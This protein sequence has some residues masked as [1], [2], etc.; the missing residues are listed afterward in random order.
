MTKLDKIQTTKQA[1][2]LPEQFLEKL[3]TF[4]KRIDQ[5]AN[6]KIAKSAEELDV[7]QKDIIQDRTRWY[8]LGN[9]KGRTATL[10]MMRNAKGILLNS[11][12]NIL[13]RIGSAASNIVLT[14]IVV[15]GSFTNMIL[16]TYVMSSGSHF[17]ALDLIMSCAPAF[18]YYDSRSK[19]WLTN[20]FK[21]E[22]I[23]DEL[24]QL[25]T[26]LRCNLYAEKEIQGFKRTHKYRVINPELFESN[27]EITQAYRRVLNRLTSRKDSYWK[28]THEL[29]TQN[30]SYRKIKNMLSRLDRGE[31]Y[32]SRM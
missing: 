25:E 14:P 19:E 22:E 13:E 7:I 20:Q 6:K 32:Q 4:Q 3:N 10:N 5:I 24:V 2:L 8:V 23:K 21:R 16:M 29:N 27:K 31:N 9:E 18:F 15:I 11:H 17:N 28:F 1:V 12:R 26:Y 30:K